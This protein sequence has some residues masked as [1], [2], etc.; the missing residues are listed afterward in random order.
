MSN[1]ELNITTTSNRLDLCA[2]TIW[3]FLNQT[4]KPS[5][6]NVWVS[7]EPYLIDE[8]V[9]EEPA[10][11]QELRKIS[12][13]IEF[14]WTENTGPYRKL[15]PALQAANED[16]ILVYADDDTIYKS[17]WLEKL[18]SKFNS[19]GGKHVIASRC[20]ELGR[21]G[22]AGK[23]SYMLLSL[24]RKER[25]LKENFLVTGVGGVV[26]KPSH[27]ATEFWSNTDFLKVCPKADDIWISKI[28]ERS[29]SSVVTCPEANEELLF[30]E[31]G[32][33]LSHSNK[34]Q[35]RGLRRQLN[36]LKIQTLGRWGFPVCNNDHA[37]RAVDSYFADRG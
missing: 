15:F 9:Q 25:L 23:K 2:Q 5:K 16:T 26:L 17:R 3:S 20:R 18:I 11:V 31:H 32:F 28:L 27:I 10:W 29:G 34:L 6:I 14:R 22:W 30:I 7:K 35:S 8:G 13:I 33:A 1:I 12:D 37:I 36:K 19:Y 24:I 4:L 21:R